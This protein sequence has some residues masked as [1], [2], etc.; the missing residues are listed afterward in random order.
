[1]AFVIPVMQKNYVLFPTQHQQK[2]RNRL[3][4][5]P[6][7]ISLPIFPCTKQNNLT[8]S[9]KINQKNNKIIRQNNALKENLTKT[10]ESGQNLF[11]KMKKITLT[12]SPKLYN[13]EKKQNDNNTNNNNNYNNKLKS[14]ILNN[15]TLNLL[16]NEKENIINNL[17]NNKNPNKQI[18]KKS[19]PN[20]IITTKETDLNSESNF[21][22]CFI[23]YFLKFLITFFKKIFLFFLII[24]FL[25]EKLK[26]TSSI[27]S[28]FNK[29]ATTNVFNSLP[30]S[31][32][33]AGAFTARVSRSHL[34]SKRIS[35]RRIDND[36]NELQW[37]SETPLAR[38]VHFGFCEQIEYDESEECLEL[39]VSNEKEK[40]GKLKQLEN[41]LAAQWKLSKNPEINSPQTTNQ[42]SFSI[43]S[44]QFDKLSRTLSA[45]NLNI[46]SKETNKSKQNN[47]NNN[48]SFC[49][50]SF[51]M[52]KNF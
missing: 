40:L 25:G 8:S 37:S 34:Q 9:S 11:D 6:I 20:L 2:I 44:Q 42:R 14:K 41:K 19:L 4:N 45:E 43:K 50:T 17:K 32:T 38:H 24:T 22:F 16:T 3:T 21:I 7:S 39:N 15:S 33:F 13:I 48:H 5:V 46:I 28:S 30:P 36:E 52:S 47:I 49:W 1:M 23:C 26:C 10:V 31:P 27:F 18:N 51:C 12:H 29:T 35:I